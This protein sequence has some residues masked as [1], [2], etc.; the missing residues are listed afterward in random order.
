[1][2]ISLEPG[3]FCTLALTSKPSDFLQKSF[4]DPQ[5]VISSLNRWEKNGN[6]HRLRASGSFRALSFHVGLKSGVT[7]SKKKR[8]NVRPSCDVILCD[9]DAGKN[10]NLENKCLRESPFTEMTYHV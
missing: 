4:L 2:P 9:L 5:H 3:W 1:V 6:P 7:N 8:K 10:L